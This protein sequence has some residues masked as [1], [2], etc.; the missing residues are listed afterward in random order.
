MNS[1]AKQ[2]A[3]AVVAVC[4]L[5]L[6][7]GADPTSQS[8]PRLRNLLL[9]RP[10]ADTNRDGVLTL[11]EAQDFQRRMRAFVE[12]ETA[13]VSAFYE[14]F[15][16][17]FAEVRYG[18]HDRNVLD[19][20]VAEGEAPRPLVVYIHGGG[21][22][23]GDKTKFPTEQFERL[24]AAGI[25]VASISYRYSTIEP[26]PTP[27]RDGGLAVQ[28]LRHHSGKYKID[29][30]RVACYGSSAGAV[31]SLW[32]AFHDDLADAGA[33]DPVLRQSTRLT[34]AGAIAAPTTL[35]KQSMDEWFGMKV[36]THPAI[37][38]LFG[39]ETEQELTSEKVRRLALEASPISH[40]TRDD[41]PVFLDYPQRHEPLPAKHSANLAVH[42]PLFGIKLKEAA[43]KIGVEANFQAANQQQ[44]R[45]TDLVDFLIKKLRP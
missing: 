10:Q 34:C 18:P 14:S 2:F 33:E 7:E 25:S 9:E 1:F 20:W 21:W 29:P 24:L 30:H 42:H 28:F 32:L 41:P 19:L 23:G 43:D 36:V 37:L 31:T 11:A 39:V 13:K 27:M 26:Y 8:D 38:P 15:P 5:G 16:P 22:I 40:L 3:V 6:A 17:T 44:E 4:L 35:D 45:Y 12:N